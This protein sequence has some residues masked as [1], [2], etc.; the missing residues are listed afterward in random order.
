MKLRGQR[1]QRDSQPTTHHAKRGPGSG[2]HGAVVDPERYGR[3]RGAL[4]S[5]GPERPFV[6]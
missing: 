2:A 1:L 5:A 4:S 3:R 6:H